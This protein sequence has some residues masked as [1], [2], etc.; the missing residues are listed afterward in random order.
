MKIA[1]VTIYDSKDIHVWSGL[2]AHIARAI[3]AGGDVELYYIDNLFQKNKG[4]LYYFQ[5]FKKVLWQKLGKKYDHKR[6]PA[7]LKK[8]ARTITGELRPGT[9]VI[10]SDSSLPMAYLDTPIPMVMYSDATFAGLLGFYTSASDMVPGMIKKAN[11]IEHRAL[12]AC[13]LLLYSSDWAARTAVTHYGVDREKIRVVPFGANLEEDKSTGV[14]KAMID[15]RTTSSVCNL[16]F[17]G[18]D[19]ERKGGDFA[20]K[21]AAELNTLGVDVRLQIIGARNMPALTLP[22][23]V[24]NYGFI[25]KSTAE[26]KAKLNQ[27]MAEAHFLLMPTRADCTPLVFSEAGSF[28]VPSITNAVGGIPS[29]IT[30][31]INGFAFPAGSTPGDYAQYIQKV[32][33]D[34]ERYKTMCLH[35]LQEYEERLNWE[36]TGKSIVRLLNDIR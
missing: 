1:Y 15:Q 34:R 14:V 23:Y 13:S 6:S 19:W 35:S 10:F 18:V 26:G 36:T 5:G 29:I 24:T 16:L 28:G 17:I 31:D 21:V 25:S 2:T 8:F 4:L 30:N 27:L 22:S 7:L 33:R 20:L 9:D 32:F 11:V 12:Q 3:A